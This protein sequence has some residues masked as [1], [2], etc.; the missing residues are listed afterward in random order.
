V[1]TAGALEAKIHLAALL[2]RVAKGEKIT[3][4]RRGIPGAV[5]C[6]LWKPKRRCPIRTSSRGCGPFANA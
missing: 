6:Q 2:D 5:P 1:E 3:I 4:T